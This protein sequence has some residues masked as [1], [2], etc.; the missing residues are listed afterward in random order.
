MPDEKPETDRDIR[1]GGHY[2]ILPS[3]HLRTASGNLA[4]QHDDDDSP[5]LLEAR[6][7]ETVRSL[8][9]LI[10]SNRELDE[11]LR[12]G[13]D[14][15]ELLDALREND[16]LIVRK[17]KDVRAMSRRLKEMGVGVIP[18]E[19]DMPV[20]GGSVVLRKLEEE[21]RTR[22]EKCQCIEKEE[23]GGLYL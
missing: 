7:S 21:R 3:P 4:T 12:E 9:R 14:D 16:E 19:E 17:T 11:A 20:Y 8:R 6:L 10:D 13:A 22:E 15:V 2:R 5:A 23:G 18:A 1:P